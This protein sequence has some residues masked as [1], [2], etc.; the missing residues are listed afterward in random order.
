M[1]KLILVELN[2]LNFD[3]VERY[4]ARGLLPAFSR[5]IGQF[6]YRRTESEQHFD[7]IEPWIQWV[8]V[9]TGKS[10]GEHGV[11][12]LGDGPAQAGE[13][14]WEHLE[15]R[16]FRVGA[17]SP[18][19]AAN[20]LRNPAFF[21]PDPWISTAVSAPAV[22]KALY[23]AVAQGVND[24]ARSKITAASAAKLLLGLAVYSRKRHV[25]TYLG[26]LAKSFRRHWAR[27]TLLDQLLGDCFI[28]LWQEARPD[29]SSV[30]LNGAAHIQHHYLFNSEAYS[31]QHQNPAWYVPPGEDPVLEMYRCYDRFLAG[32]LEL[33]EQPRLIIATGLHQDPVERPVYYYRLRDHADFLHKIGLSF[34]AVQ[35]RMSRD[36]VVEFG[37]AM[38]AKRA[39][40][41]LL[42]GLAP[43]G[44][45]LFEVDNRGASLFVTLSYPD[46]ID[47]GMRLSF[48]ARE[49]ADFGQ[50]AVFVAVKN[51]Q[52]NGIGY[53]L[54]TGESKASPYDAPA[55][56]KGIW[57]RVV[58]AF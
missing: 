36:F 30:F 23:E 50:E 40:E 20:R 31:G 2:E 45:G 29:F 44:Q 39:E 38:E 51:A 54:D 28:K 37:D 8:S 25:L 46:R 58:A 32:L 1:G 12:R 43:D 15:N 56:L 3:Y 14:I 6:G 9:H 49:I 48:G 11:F 24:N 19:N 57:D 17:F 35:P 47:S 26:T 53:L 7:W 21:I 13:Q 4:S 18:M 22:A 5:L 16:G 42:L 10:Y 34:K 33:P 41:T 27:A 52:H 55:P